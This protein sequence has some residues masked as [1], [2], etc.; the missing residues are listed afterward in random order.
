MSVATTAKQAFSVRAMA[1]LLLPTTVHR[2][3]RAYRG[4][5]HRTDPLLF[6]T[7]ARRGPLVSLYDEIKTLP[8]YFTYDDVVAF[9]LLLQ[10]QTASGVSGDLLEIG[11]YHGRSTAV[12]GRVV[13]PGERL[14][15]C[16]TFEQPAEETYP[17][18]PSVE[19]LRRTL[20]RLAPDLRHVD[21]HASR[22]DQLDLDGAVLRFA[23][24]DGGHSYNVALH[25][26]RLAASHLAP[27]GII[28]VDDYQH[29]EWQDVTNAVDDFVIESGFEVLA[30]VNRWAES[31]RKIYL[32]PPKPE[33]ARRRRTSPLNPE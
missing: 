4:R 7:D 11:S 10:V 22:S 28:A 6:G 15:V 13:Q 2:A 29:P 1:T 12:I 17:D 5:W 32:G 19:G 16:D 14:I 21:I 23:H 18:P 27:G 9:T 24:I 3:Y 25:D 8:G 30:D 33:T 26:L 20:A 31:G